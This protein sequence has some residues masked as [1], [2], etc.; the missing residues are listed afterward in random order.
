MCRKPSFFADLTQYVSR[1]TSGQIAKA[2]ES[3]VIP[4]PSQRAHVRIKPA[5][6]MQ[7]A[8]IRMSSAMTGRSVARYLH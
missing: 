1:Y 7:T 6:N 5:W 2:N 3:H 8:S 4:A